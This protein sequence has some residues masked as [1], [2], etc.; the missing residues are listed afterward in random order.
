M[1]SDNGQRWPHNLPGDP[2]FEEL[3]REAT[4]DELD[5]VEFVCGQYGESGSS[6]TRSSRVAEAKAATVVEPAVL[7]E[8]VKDLLGGTSS[9]TNP[10]EAEQTV[11]DWLS[12]FSAAD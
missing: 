5:S 2:L 4:P 12:K 1:D 7:S 10:E 11:L 8:G 3:V 9:L 6:V